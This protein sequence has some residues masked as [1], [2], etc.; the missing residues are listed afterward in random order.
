MRLSTSSTHHYFKLA[1][2]QMT[3]NFN[4]LS[5][6]RMQCTFLILVLIHSFTHSFS[7]NYISPS[8]GLTDLSD[9]ELVIIHYTVHWY[10]NLIYRVSHELRS[11]LRESVPHVKVYRYNP[12]HLY[13]KLNSF[14]DNGKRK[15]DILRLH[16]LYV[17][18]GCNLCPSLRGVSCYW[19]SAYGSQ[20]SGAGV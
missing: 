15:V 10:I 9:T 1:H 4:Q 7:I 14:R 12:K 8:K 18:A 5:S 13:P 16:A 19:I 11:L 6:A 20:E 2:H 17:S 3:P